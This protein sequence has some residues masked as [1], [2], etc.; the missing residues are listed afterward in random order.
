MAAWQGISANPL[1]AE[2]AKRLGDALARQSPQQLRVLDVSNTQLTSKAASDAPPPTNPEKAA[3]AAAPKA[4]AAAAARGP[5][6]SSPRDLHCPSDPDEDLTGL[7]AIMNF[8][9]NSKIDSL[10]LSKNGIGIG[11]MRLISKAFNSNL[12]ELV[13]RGNPLNMRQAEKSADDQPLRLF[14]ARHCLEHL[15]PALHEAQVFTTDEFYRRKTD[16][17][18]GYGFER[19]Q[20][21][22]LREELRSEEDI[23][24]RSGLGGGGVM[25]VPARGPVSRTAPS[26]QLRFQQVDLSGG[27]QKRKR[28]GV[29]DSPEE[30]REEKRVAADQPAEMSELPPLR[31]VTRGITNRTR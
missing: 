2:G 22:Q 20:I 18:L 31:R 25:S 28:K 21:T 6:R 3:A 8:V 27:S 14:M 29:D 7:Q 11:G 1:K 24:S 10:D 17:L 19:T 23:L 30:V 15:V 12:K 5:T 26:L 16:E 13:L 4:A 9:K